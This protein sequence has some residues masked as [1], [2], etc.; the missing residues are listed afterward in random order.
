MT[1]DFK[2]YEDSDLNTLVGD[3]IEL[4]ELKAGYTKRFTFYIY[5]SSKY[6]YKEINVFF[7]NTEISIVS[8]PEEMKEKTTEKVVFEWKPKVDVEVGL[9]ATLKMNG[10]KVV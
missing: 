5:N 10:Y 6:P 3:I 1:D 2:I 4:G 7:D 8:A 9:K